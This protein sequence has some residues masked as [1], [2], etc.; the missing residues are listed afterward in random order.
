[1]LVIPFLID[2]NVPDSVSNFFRE[3]GHDV[4]LVRDLL[5]R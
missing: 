4:R 1:M 5:P 2:E 3:R